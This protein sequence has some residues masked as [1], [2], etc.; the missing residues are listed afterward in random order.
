[1]GG[2]HRLGRRHLRHP[3]ALYSTTATV[4]SFQNACPRWS[5]GSTTSWSISDG[6]VIYPHAIWGQKGFTFGDW[7]QPV[8]DNRKPRPTIG[9]DCAA[10]LYHFISTD[11]TARIAGIVGDTAL[12]ASL[13]TRADQ[14]RAAFTHEFFTASGRLAHNDQTS[15]ALAFLYGLVP[16]EHF[17][18]AKAHF[19]RIVTDA[20]YLIGTASSAR[21]HSCP[22]CPCSACTT[23]RARSS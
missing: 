22:R 9:D 18:A 3:L 19:A 6:P 11:L 10:T 2:F 21:P 16:P 23:W 13:Q 14:I 5:A 20:N 7:L 17:D 15:Y 4:T 1:M 8:G 12:A